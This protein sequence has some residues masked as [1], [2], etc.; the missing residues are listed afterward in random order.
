MEPINTAEDTPTKQDDYNEY[1]YQDGVT[2]SIDGAPGWYDPLYNK[3][4][5]DLRAEFQRRNPVLLAASKSKD[6]LI[7]N[8]DKAIEF[9]N[10][11]NNTTNINVNDT[12]KAD[13]DFE[14]PVKCGGGWVRAFNLCTNNS[15][16]GCNLLEPCGTVPCF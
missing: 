4:F 12:A 14:C 8:D 5:T 16:V 1:D 3:I 10:I 9:D 15:N 7:S 2:N 13:G 11:A 6:R